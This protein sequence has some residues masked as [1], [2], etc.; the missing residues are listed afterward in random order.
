MK[1]QWVAVILGAAGLAAGAHAQ[2]AL[3]DGRG[4]QKNT[5]KYDTSLG[6]ENKGFDIQ[7]ARMRDAIVFGRAP[8]GLT[9]S[10]RAP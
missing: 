2:N 10:P 6:P 8:G 7:A 9:T 4:M 1:H 5:N 3:G